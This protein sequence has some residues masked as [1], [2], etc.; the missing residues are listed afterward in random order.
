MANNQE[1]P[2]QKPP[3]ILRGNNEMCEEEI[4]Y[5]VM[6]SFPA[7]DPPSWTLGISPL[8]KFRSEFDGEMISANE[9][10]HQNER[11]E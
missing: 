1:K 6:E 5:N 7:S 10:T 4:D 2:H 11:S 8:K 9:P 3:Q